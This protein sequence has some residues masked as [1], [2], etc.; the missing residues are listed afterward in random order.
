[1]PSLRQLEYLVAI[2]D[3]RNFRRAAERVGASQ[4]TLSAQLKTLEQRLG[5]PLIE[6]DRH[7]VITTPVGDQV[8]ALARRV[9]QDVQEIRDVAGRHGQ[10]FSGTIR[11]GLPP[12]IGP[13]LL[14]KIVPDLHKAYP[15][16][17]LYVREDK[18][19]SLPDGLME[20]RYDVLVTPLPVR[21]L[22]VETLPLFREPLF[23]AMASDHELAKNRTVARAD[24]KDQAVLA[25]ESG[26]QL[27]EQV[28]A[29][30]EEFGAT[31]L[32]DYEGTSLDTLREMVGMGM[33]LSFL[34]G[35]YVRSSLGQDPSI[36]VSELKDRSLF[37]TIGLVWRKTSFR[38]QEFETLA[39]HLKRSVRRDFSGFMLL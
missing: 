3:A 33:G 1:M 10:D 23:V 20:G 32:F 22:N 14:P 30:C 9:L 4:P 11:L 18:P 24:L 19:Q 21:D 36:K 38:A 8:V 26:H 37:R 17:K 29:V 6:R 27:H 25:L 5:A 35:L 13:Y 7:S 31:L 15:D 39:E 34:P 2:S 12:T 28:E 16:L